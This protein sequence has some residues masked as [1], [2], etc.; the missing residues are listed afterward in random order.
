MSEDNLPAV[1]DESWGSEGASSTDM[2]IPRIQLCHDIS[3]AVKKGKARPGEL[4]SSTSGEVLAKTG[5]SVEIIPIVTFRDWIINDVDEK[6]R[7]KYNSKVPMTRDNENWA[8]EE[9][10]GGKPIRRVACLNFLCLI[11]SKLD[12]LPFM[13]TFKKSSY[14]AGKKLSTHF[15]MSAMKKQPP[16]SQAFLISGVTKTYDGF[17]FSALDVEPSRASTPQEL[18]VA[19]NWYG[20]FKQGAIKTAEEVE[21]TVGDEPVLF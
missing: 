13:V 21:P 6:G 19:K 8:R 17:T 5:A 16:A 14:Y 3:D 15:Q 2:L 9:V 4:I 10:V 18:A 12:E 20:I 11:P 1:P 7:D